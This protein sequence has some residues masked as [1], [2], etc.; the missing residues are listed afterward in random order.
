MGANATISSRSNAESGFATSRMASRRCTRCIV[1]S[2]EG[3]IST[4]EVTAK[5]MRG[6]RDA[7]RSVR[8]EVDVVAEVVAST[9]C[10]ESVPK[11][12]LVGDVGEYLS[13]PGEAFG[14]LVES[15]SAEKAKVGTRG[16][17]CFGLAKGS[18]LSMGVSE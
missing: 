2:F 14:R 11:N 15:G 18:D 16:D 17:D 12:A 6:T 1:V 4:V 10:I 3:A 7:S 8:G 13:Q 5:R 9:P